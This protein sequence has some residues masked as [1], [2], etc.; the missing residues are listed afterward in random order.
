[1]RVFP[2][3]E[4][5]LERSVPEQR[6]GT[7]G[8]K[9]YSCK[10]R[11]MIISKRLGRT[12]CHAAQHTLMP[13]AGWKRKEKYVQMNSKLC[14]IFMPRAKNVNKKQT[15]C[16]FR[17][18]ITC[19]FVPVLKK[20]QTNSC[21]DVFLIKSYKKCNIMFKCRAVWLLATEYI[22]IEKYNNFK[23]SEK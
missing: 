19:V 15:R 14:C 10:W 6:R 16:Q 5:G 9:F 20:T 22:A 17:C 13:H 4:F 1:M 7:Q 11:H 23:T 2:Q 18:F 12:H 21:V 3:E 8:R